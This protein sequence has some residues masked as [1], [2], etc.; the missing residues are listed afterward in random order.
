MKH[1]SQLLAATAF[2]LLAPTSSRAQHLR[3]GPAAGWLHSMA[4]GQESGDGLY[5][6]V[7]GEM[8]FSGSRSGWFAGASLLL[9]KRRW[10]SVGYLYAP[11]ADGQS[12]ADTWHYTTYSLKVPLSIGY[13]VRLSD[14][15][16][17]YAAARPYLSIG[18]A[19]K[20]RLT[21][22]VPDDGRM[23]EKQVS[24]NVFAD[25]IMN[26]VGWGI[27]VSAGAELF[28]NCRVGIAYDHSMSDIFKDS[29]AG[30]RHR[31]LS[32]GIGYMF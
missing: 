23:Y 1:I 16:R 4:S 25:H 8:D 27:G 28:G 12:A 26:R 15:A 24:D 10:D 7:A 14:A 29:H 11:G 5:A 18:L 22:Y 2:C 20:E 32:V 21:T 30:G 9:E 17:L 13:G 6:G 3:I 31:T 19:G